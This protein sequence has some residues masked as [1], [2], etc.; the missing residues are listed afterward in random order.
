MM[1]SGETRD[2][3]LVL[4]IEAA[5]SISALARRL[6][7]SQPSVST[8]TRI[9]ANRIVAVEAVTGVSRERLRPD[10][11]G[12][13]TM[14]AAPGS[15]PR[16]PI[17]VDE[18]D[19]ARADI[20]RLLATLLAKP[21]SQEV[22]GIVAGLEGDASPFGL[23]R[24]A[25]AEAAAAA[26]EQT[27]GPEYFNL[28]VGVGRGE[29]LQYGSFYL[30]GFLHERPLAR[31]RED[32]KRLGIERREGVFEPEDQLATLLEIMAGLIAGD[33][34]APIAEQKQFFERHIQPWAPR[35][36][37]DIAVA[38]SAV[39]YTRVAEVG[40]QWIEIETEAFALPD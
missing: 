32:L 24:I 7:I 21:P 13:A 11:F 34:Q 37:A 3:G 17:A 36:F 39:F 33:F 2:E 18:I 14:T 10:L 8:W 29:I 22:L 15:M 20:Y 1:R 28:F 19:L 40:R 26:T 30:T 6:G 38:P 4:A 27:V 31:V 25:L 12:E 35:C 16:A 9:P 23:A 5:G